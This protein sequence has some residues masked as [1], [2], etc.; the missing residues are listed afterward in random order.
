ATTPAQKQ[1][2]AN[3]LALEQLSF[4]QEQQ[5]LKQME[6]A[7]KAQETVAANKSKLDFS[8]ELQKAREEFK[9]RN[10]R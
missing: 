8:N 1:D 6:E 10:S 7:I 3:K 9:K 2:V 4:N 5:A